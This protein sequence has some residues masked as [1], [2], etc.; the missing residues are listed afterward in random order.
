MWIFEEKAVEDS[1]R[2]VDEGMAAVKVAVNN[3]T[4][5]SGEP[6]KFAHERLA[7]ILVSLKS[8]VHDPG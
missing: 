8:L 7:V 2:I 4:N 5:G 3:K 1:I 6:N